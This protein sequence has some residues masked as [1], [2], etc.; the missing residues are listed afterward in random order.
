MKKINLNLK[1]KGKKV[2]EFAK[3]NPE[4]VVA[5]TCSVVGTAA[6]IIATEKHNRINEKVYADALQKIVDQSVLPKER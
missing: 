4:V 1:E 2:V 3:E 6:K 5:I